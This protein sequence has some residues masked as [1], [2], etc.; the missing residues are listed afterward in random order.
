MCMLSRSVVSN[1]ETPWTVAH[2]APLFLGFFRQEYWNGLPF[3]PQGIFLTQGSN[4]CLQHWQVD[5]LPLRHLGSPGVGEHG[6]KGKAFVKILTY[7]LCN[8][9]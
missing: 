2:Q 3:P 7:K 4:S 9:E 8:H 5:S 1:S 6:L